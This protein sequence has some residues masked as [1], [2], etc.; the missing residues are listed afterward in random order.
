MRPSLIAWSPNSLKRGH[1]LVRFC[2]RAQREFQGLLT[3]LVLGLARP[4]PGAA[5]IATLNPDEENAS[6]AAVLIASGL[7]P[8]TPLAC[9]APMPLG[10]APGSPLNSS[11]ARASIAIVSPDPEVAEQAVAA[12]ARRLG[13]SPDP[14]RIRY[15][16]LRFRSLLHAYRDAS[17]TF[18]THVLL[19]GTDPSRRRMHVHLTHGSGPKPDTTFRGPANVLASITPQWVES[20][21][22][23]YRL[24]PQTRVV[25]AMPRLEVMRRASGDRSV[26]ERLGLD[27]NRR[28]IVWAPTYRMV[29]RAAGEIRRS[30]RPFGEGSLLRGEGDESDLGRLIASS[31][32]GGVQFVAKV[33]P[34]EA[35]DFSTL[36]MPVLSNR[37]LREKGVTPYELFGAADLLV[38]DYSSVSIE[39][40]SLRLPYALFRPDYEEFAKSYRGFRKSPHESPELPPTPLHEWSAA[41]GD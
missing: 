18:S 35:D 10:K 16:P 20:Q 33:H 11:A 38:T 36:G 39:R 21:L 9:G 14:S 29:K 41:D 19:P 23:E 15:I 3:R 17:V 30:G 32:R 5:A 13:L 6:V 40:A 8:L 22:R 28:L 12:A 24:P 26:C 1:L 34:H 4:S 31:R 25:H 37:D 2:G 27:P 7:D